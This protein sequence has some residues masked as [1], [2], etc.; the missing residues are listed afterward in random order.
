MHLRQKWEQVTMQIPTIKRIYGFCIDIATAER[1][2][3][4]PMMPDDR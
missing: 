4:Q 2:Y 1:R 3:K